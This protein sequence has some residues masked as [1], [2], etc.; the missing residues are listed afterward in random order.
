MYGSRQ[1]SKQAR[2]FICTCNPYAVKNMQ[3][4]SSR[5]A[6]GWLSLALATLSAAGT[7]LAPEVQVDRLLVQAERQTRDGDHWSAV[8]TLDRASDAYEQHGLAIPVGFWFQKA[9]AYRRAGLHERAIEAA[10]KYLSKAGREGEHYKAALELLDAAEAAVIESER[11]R[12]RVEAD[13]KQRQRAAAE[14]RT[15]VALAIPE[16]VSIPASDSIPPFEMAKYEVTFT[17]WD[18]CVEYG[19]CVRVSDNGWGRNARPRWF[20]SQR[21][22]LSPLS[23]W[24]STR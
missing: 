10:T 15:A 6:G 24:Q 11:A 3:K 21:L 5:L 18:V 17:Q 7:E 9:S 12:A 13:A 19:P 4:V 8:V 22:T 1:L 14:R 20:P 16:M 23:R 2:V